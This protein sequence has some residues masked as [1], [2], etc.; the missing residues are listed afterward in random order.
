MLIEDKNLQLM[1]EMTNKYALKIK[2]ITTKHPISVGF[3]FATESQ[4]NRYEAEGRGFRIVDEEIISD[5]QTAITD[6]NGTPR[7]HNTATGR[8]V[9]GLWPI[10]PVPASTN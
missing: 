7:A 3:Y 2:A 1:K 8:T 5:L 10:E 6:Y 9:C 4:A